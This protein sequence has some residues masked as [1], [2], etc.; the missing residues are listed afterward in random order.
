MS[1]EDPVNPAT[2]HEAPAVR[3]VARTLEA[4]AF[5]PFGDVID[6]SGQP[7]EFIN[8]G[9]CG[10]F[11]DRARLS[12]DAAGRLGVSVFDSRC[13]TLPVTVEFLERHPLA[14]QAFL[15]LS[16]DPFLVVVARDRNGAP[17]APR[18]FTTRPGQGVNLLRGT[19]HG[20]LTPL[21]SSGL[22]A[23][24]DRIGPGENCEVH[25]LEAPVLVEAAR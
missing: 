15:P 25:H 9:A 21:G 10:R 8:G 18:A 22:F 3:I 4:D 20:V 23:V 5:A 13:F 12:V 14:S 7:S 1:M 16:A 2:N 24:I 17:G 6:A 11:D 19:W